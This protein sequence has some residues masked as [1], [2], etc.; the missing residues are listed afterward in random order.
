MLTQS[1]T[2]NKGFLPLSYKLMDRYFLGGGEDGSEIH[3]KQREG[4]LEEAD[5]ALLPRAKKRHEQEREKGRLE[6]CTG[7]LASVHRQINF[8]HKNAHDGRQ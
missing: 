2:F 5:D 3:N 6:R 4:F 7:R 8:N 1:V